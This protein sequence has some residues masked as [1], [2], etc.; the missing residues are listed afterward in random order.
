[1]KNTREFKYQAGL[2]KPALVFAKTGK[3]RCY[4]AAKYFPCPCF[5]ALKINRSPPL[6]LLKTEKKKVQDFTV[7]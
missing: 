7:F 1:L 3:S 4:A 5:S 2:C 6:R